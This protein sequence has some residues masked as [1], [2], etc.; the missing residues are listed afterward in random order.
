MKL[1]N[2]AAAIAAMSIAGAV[3]AAGNQ[4]AASSSPSN[5]PSYSGS[6]NGNY[7][8]SQQQGQQDSH[9][10]D[11]QQ[12]LKQQGFNPGPVDGVMGPRTEQALRTFQQAHGLQASGSLDERTLSALGVQPAGGLQE[13]ANSQQPGSQPPNGVD[14]AGTI[15]HGSTSGMSGDDG[16]SRGDRGAS[17]LGNPGMTTRS[18]ASGSPGSSMA[19]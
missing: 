4:S 18:G 17:D 7:S 14:A 11:V 15:N 10:R 3:A 9:V 19:Q 6:S 12:T 2:I 16:N 5:E 1:R 13:S 8:S